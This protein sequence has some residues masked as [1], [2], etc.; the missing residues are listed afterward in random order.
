[1]DLKNKVVWVTGAS[2]GIGEALVYELAKKGCKM[3]LSS[4]KTEALERVKS[5]CNLNDDD[6]LILPLDLAAHD[7]MH[8]KTD[9]V[10]EKFGR[11]DCVVHNGGISQRA[12][13]ADT[14]FSVDKTIMDVNYFGAVALTKAVLPV[15]LKQKSGY[16]VVISSLTGKLGAKLRSAYAASKHALHGFFDSLRAE[17]WDQNIKVTIVCPG[18]IQTN[19]SVNAITGDG[20]TYNKMDET[21]AKGMPVNACAGKIIRA[22]ENEK[23]EMVVGGKEIA[24][25]YLKRFFPRLL[26]MLMQK[27]KVT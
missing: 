7:S 25:I 12:F 22:I 17:Y 2:S 8:S 26:S 19:V 13:A 10:L 9:A 15:F 20:S 18:F 27:R 5:N 16:F 14:D 11:I 4:R 3:I 23:E 1:M 6:I 21:Q 24:A